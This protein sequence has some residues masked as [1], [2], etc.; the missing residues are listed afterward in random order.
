M[1]TQYVIC[2]L[3]KRVLLGDCLANAYWEYDWRILGLAIADA[4]EPSR[5]VQ[6]R[7]FEA[8]RGQA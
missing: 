6:S 1:R 8:V 7:P 2:V 3:A 5:V 4:T